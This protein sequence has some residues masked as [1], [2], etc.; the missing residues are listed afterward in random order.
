[1]EMELVQDKLSKDCIGIHALWLFLTTDHIPHNSRP[2]W[3][4]PSGL[5]L[6]VAFI[7]TR[8]RSARCV[9]V[10][11]AARCVEYRGR[12]IVRATRR[13]QGRRRQFAR[14]GAVARENGGAPRRGDVP[15]GEL[16]LRD[17]V[18]GRRRSAVATTIRSATATRVPTRC[19]EEKDRF[20]TVVQPE[21]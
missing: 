8:V 19:R 17:A 12:D 7:V 4:H 15:V 21:G 20:L 13:G 14:G 1:M 10:W 3:T 6:P 2:R 18:R 9:R 16:R 5:H 11:R